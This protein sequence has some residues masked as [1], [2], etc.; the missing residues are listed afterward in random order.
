MLPFVVESVCKGKSF[1]CNRQTFSKVFFKKFFRRRK[2]ASTGC[3][4]R[5]LNAVKVRYLDAPEP[6]L[7]APFPFRLSSL[8][9]LSLSKAGAKLRTFSL[10]PTFTNTFFQDFCKKIH[11]SLWFRYVLRHVLRKKE[12]ELQQDTPCFITRARMRARRIRAK[13]PHGS[14]KK[15][16]NLSSLSQKG[17]K[18]IR[19]IGINS[20]IN[21]QSD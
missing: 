3:R 10:S 9:R 12:R 6:L 15:P 11:K 14:R 4:S 1:F 5:S 16:K 18:N 7:P 19:L 21:G 2:S 17:M 20:V 13:N 8:Q